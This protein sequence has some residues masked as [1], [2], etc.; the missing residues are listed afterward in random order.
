MRIRNGTD[1]LAWALVLGILAAGVILANAAWS[2]AS[3][4]FRLIFG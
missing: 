4:L 1:L 3:K 2:A